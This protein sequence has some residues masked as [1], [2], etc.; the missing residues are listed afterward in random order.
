MEGEVQH[1]FNYP[2]QI[3]LPVI[4]PGT[5]SMSKAT[6]NPIHKTKTLMMTLAKINHGL[7]VT[8]LDGKSTLTTKEETFPKTKEQFK[9]FFTDEWEPTSPHKGSRV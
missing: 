4:K 5:K 3:L 7:M 6:Y 1:T 8:S 9:K 2:M